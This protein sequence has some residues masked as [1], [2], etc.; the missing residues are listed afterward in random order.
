MRWWSSN[1]GQ[2][3]LK[4]YT[5]L[6]VITTYYLLP[7]S[8][9]IV[10]H[11]PPVL[12][13]PPPP[14]S[15][16]CSSLSPAPR[17]CF[18]HHVLLLFIPPFPPLACAQVPVGPWGC[19]RHWFLRLPASLPLRPCVVLRLLSYF[20]AWYL[21]RWTLLRAKARGLGTF[22]PWQLLTSGPRLYPLL[23]HSGAGTPPSL[24]P[25]CHL[26]PIRIGEGGGESC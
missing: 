12:F 6:L 10:V 8:S 22:T 13:P 18:F 3:L 26:D 7:I 20:G 15:L 16:R 21:I 17:A 25:P 11:H 23:H 14:A 9:N 4:S 5:L 24:S 1:L 2:G 19:A